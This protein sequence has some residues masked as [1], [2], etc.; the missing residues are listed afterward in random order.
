MT[1]AEAE[2]TKDPAALLVAVGAEAFPDRFQAC[3]DAAEPLKEP[4]ADEPPH[5]APAGSGETLAPLMFAPRV[6]AE[7]FIESGW[8]LRYH[9]GAWYR[10]DGRAYAPLA[11]E[12]LAARVAEL[13]RD[14]VWLKITRKE[15]TEFAGDPSRATVNN[16]LVNLSGEAVISG[17]LEPPCW[18]DGRSARNV[19]ILRNGLLD[20]DRFFDGARE[21]IERRPRVELIPGDMQ[22]RARVTFPDEAPREVTLSDEGV[23][24][25][26][27]EEFA[28]TATCVH[29]E[30]A[31]MADEVGLDDDLRL[32]GC[33]R[34]PLHFRAESG[35]AD[36][37]PD[38]FAVNSLPYEFDP[39]AE[40]PA[41]EAFLGRV[42]PDTGC[43]R[44]LSEW[45][46]W[47]LIPCQAYQ[48]LLLLRG[49]G[50]NGKSVAMGV[51]R[52]LVGARNCSAV[53]LEQL[54]LPHSLAPLVGKLLNLATEWGHIDRIG[55]MTLKAVTGGDSVTINPKHRAQ[56]EALLPTRFIVASN[57]APR[58]IDRSN[59]TWRRLMVMPLDV[60]IPLTEQR[61]LETLISELCDELPGILLWALR[62]LW[63]LR[64][65]GRFALPE[66]MRRA[67]V[68][69]REESNPAA[70]WC[71]ENLEATQVEGDFVVLTEAYS[72]Y[73]RFCDTGGYKP[74][75]RN[76]FA[77]E[78]R[79]W[80]HRQTG[81][82]ADVR[83]ERQA[84]RR[85][86]VLHGI[87]LPF[88]LEG[89][90]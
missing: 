53:P 90:D 73:R 35:L 24:S 32:K 17:A 23:W 49:E 60:T 16:V 8:R 48:K 4:P 9:R 83:R 81:T 31:S 29:A 77:R 82:T 20:L 66:A 21:E 62:G 87:T 45:F 44:V 14:R 28:R 10:F 37:T 69:I 68:D 54:H 59:A 11:E 50:A 58:V 43:Q 79:R 67:A 65:R 61:P 13:I 12:E 74:L 75:N 63:R 6:I 15:P 72:K 47:C 52:N 40:C 41:W 34:A 71:D 78:I 39:D 26:E 27:C 3:L 19:L 5:G 56:F 64:R 25:C 70:S 7:A 57:E 76:H 86:R 85:V 55:L 2:T 36:H 33:P 80:F 88:R 51:L 30:A 18:L 84:G 42:L 46:G 1:T 38:L 22:P 89:E